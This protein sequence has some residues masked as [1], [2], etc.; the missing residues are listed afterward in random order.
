MG[1]LNAFYW[2]FKLNLQTSNNIIQSPS[3]LREMHQEFLVPDL[4][5]VRSFG[6]TETPYVEFGITGD[7]LHAFRHFKQQ[8][9]QL[10]I[11]YSDTAPDSN[12]P[13]L[14]LF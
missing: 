7:K 14:S 3:A 4:D 6:P 8:T 12:D 9:Y 5:L 1:P 10:S 2:T 13:R 11:H